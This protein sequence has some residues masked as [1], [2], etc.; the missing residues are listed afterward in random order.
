MSFL[1]VPNILFKHIY[2]FRSNIPNGDVSKGE[3]IVPY[4]QPLPFKGTGY[5]RAVFVLYKQNEKVDLSSYKIS[6]ANE[7]DSRSF[8]TYD[9]YKKYQ[10]VITPAGLSFFQSKYDDSVR[11]VFHT[12]LGNYIATR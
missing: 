11:E 4:L 2:R 6:N 1:V 12:K 8:Y 9:F 7:L 5:H 3:T 10:D